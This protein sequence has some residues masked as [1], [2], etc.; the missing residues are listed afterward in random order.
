MLATP[1]VFL[2]VRAALVSQLDDAQAFTGLA[3]LRR[4]SF[5][6]LLLSL[7][8]IV[9][10][11]HIFGGSA[12]LLTV[13][14]VHD[15]LDH[16]LGGSD[17]IDHLAEVFNAY[18]IEVFCLQFLSLAFSSN[19]RDG[20]RRLILFCRFRA[21]K[22]DS[23]GNVLDFHLGLD[24]GWLGV[25]LLLVFVDYF[26]VGAG[27]LQRWRSSQLLP[28]VVVCRRSHLAPLQPYRF[29]FLAHEL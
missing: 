6:P 14:P 18:L 19:C 25:K 29:I 27:D 12:R 10:E 15:L 11:G 28:E 4:A 2:G 20:N 9:V 1:N 8:V 21:N 26:N 17:L 13:D 24:V 3:L 23:S 7:L 5:L 22:L 16:D